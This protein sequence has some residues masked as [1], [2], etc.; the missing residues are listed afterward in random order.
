MQ[1]SVIFVKKNVKMNIFIKKYRKTR[2]HC[3]Y[4]REYRSVEHGN[5]NLKYNITGITK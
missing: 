2:D 5:C 4:T 1:V 3:H